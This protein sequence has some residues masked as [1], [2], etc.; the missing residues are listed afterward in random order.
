MVSSVGFF[1]LFFWGFYCF[2]VGAVIVFTDQMLHLVPEVSMI[3]RKVEEKIVDGSTNVD[4]LV[5][6]STD[7]TPCS[8]R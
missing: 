7:R 2:S 5:V 3:N 6:E 4:C 1:W 8:F